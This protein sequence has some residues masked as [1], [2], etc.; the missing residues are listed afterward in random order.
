MRDGA[1]FPPGRVWC[2]G[3]EYWLT[4][5]FQRTLCGRSDRTKLTKARLFENFSGS[6]KTRLID[7]Y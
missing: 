7:P 3:R 2:D 4:D 6:A 5:D 1:E